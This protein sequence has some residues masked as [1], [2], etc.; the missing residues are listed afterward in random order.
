MRRIVVF[1]AVCSLA[2]PAVVQAQGWSYSDYS[3]GSYVPKSGNFI[4]SAYASSTSPS[5]YLYYSGVDFYFDSFNR[6]NILDYNN[7][8]N[9]P[10]TACDNVQA[11]VTIDQTAVPDND[12]TLSARSVS[13]NL[14]D[15]K[16]D[17][18]NDSWTNT[19]EEEAEAVALG[20]VAAG[21][22]YFMDVYWEDYRTGYVSARGQIQVQFGMS[23]EGWSDYNNCTQSSAVQ[24]I[25]RYLG[26]QGCT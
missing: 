8:G 23:N 18:E 15:P 12:E 19:L 13:T 21:Q 14:P 17:L 25:D 4:E 22:F 7:G 16:T 2:T 10:G 9:N 1:L 6:S 11:Y 26:C 5:G 3:K 24:V 20:A